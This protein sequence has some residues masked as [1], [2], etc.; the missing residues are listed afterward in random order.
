M[1][2]SSKTGFYSNYICG[3]LPEKDQNSFKT[4]G[5]QAGWPED[6]KKL[7]NF[8]TSSQNIYIKPLQTI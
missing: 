3:N 2:S 1:R 6:C 5:M 7:P 4:S 8:S